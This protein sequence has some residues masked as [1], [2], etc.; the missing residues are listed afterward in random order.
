MVR[1]GKIYK[2]LLIGLRVNHEPFMFESAPPPLNALGKDHGFPERLAVTLL[3]N[4][5]ACMKNKIKF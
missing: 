2:S 3:K 5:T 1:Q 4:Y